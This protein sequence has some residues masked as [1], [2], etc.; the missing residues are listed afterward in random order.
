M[1]NTKDMVSCTSHEDL[2][3]ALSLK[4]FV[5]AFCRNLGLQY[6]IDKARE[7]IGHPMVVHDMGF[8]ILATSYDAHEMVD[9]V[10]SENGNKYINEE[11]IQL[12]R[13][14]N[15]TEKVRKK[16]SAE[17]IQKSEPSRGTILSL[18]KVDGIEIAQFAVY[19]VDIKFEE[20][21]FK[22]IDKIS[23]LLA[24]ELQKN[25]AFNIEKRLIPNYVLI[26][27]LEGKSMD[28]DIIRK[29]LHYLNWVKEQDLYIMVISDKSNRT[30]DTK[31]VSVIPVLKDFIP[32]SNCV[33]YQS[34]IVAFI[35]QK[36]YQGLSPDSTT[37]FIIFLENNDLR[38]GISLKF[39]KLSDCKRYYSQATESLAIGKRLNITLSNFK[40]TSFNILSDLITSKYDFMDFCH[41]AILQLMDFD[42][43]NKTSLLLT[44]QYYLEYISSPNEAA[45]MLYIHRNTLF[46]RINKIKGL[47][48]VELK[49]ASEISQLYFSI[50]L[51]NIN[52]VGMVS[53]KPDFL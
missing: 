8:K 32:L 28:E 42:I 22:L 19:E 24:V 37:H 29:K 13:S 50:K 48:G 1:D 39:S 17:Y 18:I 35:P 34:D 30:L 25:N 52:G 43:E 26:D 7:I 12:I 21:H 23:Q 16:G 27:L 10:V 51:L 3:L 47:T 38:A 46:Y 33:V 41:P 40:E 15:L 9:F 14:R 31:I 4:D 5:D 45:K 2:Q 44:L 6:L 36:L 49:G 53:N 20:I 11:T